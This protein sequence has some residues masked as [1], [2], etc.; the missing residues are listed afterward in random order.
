LTLFFSPRRYEWFNHRF[1][2]INT[3]FARLAFCGKAFFSPG[4]PGFKRP[5]PC[6]R[7]PSAFILEAEQNTLITPGPTNTTFEDKWSGRAQIFTARYTLNAARYG[8]DAGGG[9]YTII[10]TDF[11][12]FHGLKVKKES[13]GYEG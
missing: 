10:T 9:F 5:L 13:L 7:S 6:P 12:D 4:A 11:T 3:D 1:T 8:L 2:R